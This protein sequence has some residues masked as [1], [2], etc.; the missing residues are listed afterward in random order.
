VTDRLARERGARESL[1]SI[2]LV[3]EAALVFF[4]TLAVFGLHLLSPGLAFSA[5][6]SLLVLLVVVS[7]LQRFVWGVWIGAALQPVLVASGI[8]VSLMYLI[9][10]GFLILWIACFSRGRALDR[11]KAGMM[12]ETRKSQE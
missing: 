4:T 11:A 6:G 9:G 7:R 5:G 1:L 10:S 8:L 12:S 3:L 2:V